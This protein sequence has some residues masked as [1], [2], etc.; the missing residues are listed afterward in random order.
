MAEMFFTKGLPATPARKRSMV[1][2]AFRNLRSS[3]AQT[4]REDGFTLLEVLVALAILGMSL[5]VLLGIFST[6]LD[7]TREFQNRDAALN[8]AKALILMDETAAPDNVKDAEGV[9][10]Q[11]LHWRVHLETYGSDQDRASWQERPVQ[12]WTT[13]GWNDH[14]RE[15]S[16]A[17]STLCLMPSTKND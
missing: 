11:Q 6:A 13:V 15:R 1:A 10:D 16:V 3:S 2:V 9:T 5:A 7:R 4:G 12:I 14:G 17:L 8:L